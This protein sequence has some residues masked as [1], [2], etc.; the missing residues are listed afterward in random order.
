MRVRYVLAIAAFVASVSLQAHATVPIANFDERA[1]VRLPYGMTA[2]A[3][4]PDDS[5][6][7]FATMKD[8]GE[9]LIVRA[10]VLLPTPFATVSPLHNY[11]ECGLLGIAFD[12]GFVTNGYVYVFATV[13]RHEQQI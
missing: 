13:S 5:Q 8:S 11:S 10:G 3:W 6:R 7:L 12:P 9:I 1:I 2:I 4:A